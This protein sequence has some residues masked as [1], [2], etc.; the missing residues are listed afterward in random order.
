MRRMEDQ[1]RSLCTQILAA[2]DDD[3]IRQ[4]VVA[5]REALHRYIENLRLRVSDYPIVTERR[6][7]NGLSPL[8][9]STP[10]LA[11]K[12]AAIG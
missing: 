4:A 10:E 1:I 5:L 7:S 11:S 12:K 2:K 9:T 8:D 3:E 6:I